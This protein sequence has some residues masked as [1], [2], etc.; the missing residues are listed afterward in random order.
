MFSTLCYVFVYYNID[1]LLQTLYI[2]YI[3]PNNNYEAVSNCEG[4]YFLLKM[5]SYFMLALYSYTLSYRLFISKRGDKNSIALTFIYT[6]HLTDI[7]VSPNMSIAEYELS[8]GVMWAF[9]T[10]LMLKM[11][12]DANDL[13][14][15][16][17]NIHYHISFIVPHV[18]VVPFKNQPIYLL[19]TILLSIPA[20]FFL[21]SLHKYKKLPFTNL[22]MLIWV[23]FML[24]NIL[25]ITQLC[26]PE[27][28]HAL[29]NL[30]DTLCKF[31]CNVVISNYNEQEIIVRENMDLQSV[32][33]VSHVV[34][35]I[36]EFENN[37]NKLTPFCSNLMRYCKKKFVDKIPKT[38][39]KLKLELLKKILPFNLD[40][41]YIGVGAIV[42]AGAGAGAGSNKEFNFICVMFMD[43]VNYTDLANRYKC[44]DTI[45]KLLDDV[46][47]HFDNIIKKYSHLQKIETIGDAYMV[48]G[49]IYRHELNY[50]VVVKEIILLALEFIKEIK[51]IKTPDNIPL[52]IRLGINL[53]TVNVG[54][55]GN[56]IPRL[57][58]VGN[59]VNV[60]ARL[61]STAEEDTIQMS[62]HVYEQAEEIDFGMNIEYIEKDNVFLKN[63]GSVITYN[64]M[65]NK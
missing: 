36:K 6:K 31:I 35:S 40:R 44:G 38:N 43:I 8:R 55:L 7:L 60:A 53:G 29:Y 16:D 50:K 61:Q 12:C 34:K 30:A 14:L 20:L 9:T 26:R 18:F 1:K 46:Y 63:I 11:Y 51:T 47:H 5:T 28:I 23:I 3:I 15:W 17:I 13:S 4:L 57:C 2:P 65:P 24:I 22:Y 10:P 21:I 62:R 56:E 27:F 49:D 52:C 54:I 19:L 37:N 48:V 25:D 59:T 32:Q 42:G 33:F 39:E 58:V 45:F 41:E 64:I